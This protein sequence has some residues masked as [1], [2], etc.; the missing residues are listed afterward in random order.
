MQ[1]K[2]P[3]YE[4]MVDELFGPVLSVYVY[5]ASRYKETLA[6]CEGASVYGLTGAVFAD[7]RAAQELASNALRNAAGNFY[8]NDK[9]TGAIVGQQAFGGS[10]K[11]GTND[12]SG[13]MANL[14][15]WT[16]T[17]TIKENF[18]PL[19]HYSYPHMA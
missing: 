13:S 7:D 3:N 9:C 4:T 11:S 10:R 19:Q 18:V 14:M 16:S 6:L 15:R 8:L 5:E 2:D 12:K 17:R 1:A